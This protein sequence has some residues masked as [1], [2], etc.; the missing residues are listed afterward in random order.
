MAPVSMR[1]VEQFQGD[2]Y[3]TRDGHAPRPVRYAVTRYQGVL[4][5]SGMPIPG[6]HRIEGRVEIVPGTDTAGLI[7]LRVGLRLEDG[8]TLG[9][10]VIDKDGRVLDEGHGPGLCRCC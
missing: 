3:L 7:G 4:P 8:R 10:T 5:G 6:L 1:L 9:V 2:G